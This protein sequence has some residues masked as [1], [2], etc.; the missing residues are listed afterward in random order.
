MPA[1][2]DRRQLQSKTLARQCGERISFHYRGSAPFTMIRKSIGEPAWKD[3]ERG[4]V[5]SLREKYGSGKQKLTM[6]ANLSIGRKA[7]VR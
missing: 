3:V 1:V 7:A 4:I 2:S 5:A 6:T